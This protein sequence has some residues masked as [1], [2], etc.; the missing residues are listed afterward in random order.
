MHLIDPSA[1]DFEAIC[2]S[3]R[4][5]VPD[6]LNIAQLVCDRHR[7]R[8]DQAALYFENRDGAQQA[9]TFGQIKSL[10]NRLANALRGLGLVAGD[11]VAIILLQLPGG[12]LR[13]HHAGPPGLHG[14]IL[15]GPY[16]G[17]DRRTGPGDA[18]RRGGRAC[19]ATR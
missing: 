14:Q 13:R 1:I 8:S 6:Q 12:Q 10:S 9:Y 5:L 16:G 19:R 7:D 3:F 17:C 4:W 11:R 15:S 2:H 18:R